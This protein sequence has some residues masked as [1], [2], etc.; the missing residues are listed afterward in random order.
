MS[1]RA[2]E[3][4]IIQATYSEWLK[5]N[6]QWDNDQSPSIEDELKLIAMTQTALE[7]IKPE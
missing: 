3:L 5:T 1:K 7:K 6:P 4:K 2:K